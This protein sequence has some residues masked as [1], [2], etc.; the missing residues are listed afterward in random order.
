MFSDKRRYPRFSYAA[1]VLYRLPDDTLWSI[2]TIVDISVGGIFFKTNHIVKERHTL[3]FRLANRLDGVLVMVSGSMVRILD[4]A[5]YGCGVAVEFSMPGS[6]PE[7]KKLCDYLMQAQPESMIP[8]MQQQAASTFDVAK[9]LSLARSI[10]EDI[11]YMNYYQILGLTHSAT[12]VQLV[13]MRNTLLLQLNLPQQ[14]SL[15]VADRKSLADAVGMVQQVGD[16]LCNPLK[17]LAYDLSQGQVDPLVVRTLAH[18]Y[19]IDIRPYSALWQQKHPDHIR[20][21]AGL[22]QEA[23]AD[24]AAGRIELAR[25]KVREAMEL[26]PFNFKY[27]INF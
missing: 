13:E 27:S 25:E 24:Q 12:T 9:S 1:P 8:S 18:D 20:K 7:I 22:W 3:Q 15:L 2:G 14:D 4:D 21:S 11:Q 16:I 6:S 5:P 17:R 19:Q 26:D 23:Q 10:L